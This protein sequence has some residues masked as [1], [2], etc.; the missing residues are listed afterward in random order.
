MSVNLSMADSMHPCEMIL[1]SRWTSA[2]S[3][4]A[5]EL[6]AGELPRLRGGIIFATMRTVLYKKLHWVP[7]E[8]LTY[9]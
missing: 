3:D 1:G 4:L 9:I 6:T 2:D 8:M 7:G 5:P